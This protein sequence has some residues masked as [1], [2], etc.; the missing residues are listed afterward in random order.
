MLIWSYLFSTFAQIYDAYGHEADT[1]SA[2]SGGRAGA[3]AIALDHVTI[4]Y[5][6]FAYADIACLSKACLSKYWN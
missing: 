1:N 4:P 3:I 5:Y 6:L 2:D